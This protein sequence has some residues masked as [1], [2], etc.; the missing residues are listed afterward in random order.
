M[1]RAI[2]PP[3]C[4]AAALMSAGCAAESQLLRADPEFTAKSLRR[5]GIAVLGVV[6]V[7]EVTQ[8]RAP[9]IAA[10]ERVLRATR[11]DVPLVAAERV[12]AAVA[13]SAYRLFLLG[14]QMRGEP[15]SSWLALVAEATRGMAR[16]GLLARVESAPVRYGTRVVAS[17]VAGRQPESEVKVAGRDAHI[18]VQ[19]YDLTTRRVVFSGK[20]VGGSDAAP[21]L[22]P[23]P[24]DSADAYPPPLEPGAGP[25]TAGPAP[26]APGIPGPSDSPS[27]LGFPEA[28]P[29]ARAAEAAF[30]IFARSLPGGPPPP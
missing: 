27:A 21:I 18:A 7:E 20:Y 13:D 19:I 1:L 8:V 2:V 11:A 3:A 9:L 28:P 17:E 16:Y 5:G 15:D 26:G 14:Y 10:S 23:V 4:A 24:P 29:V 22:R 6:Q 12:Q 25:T 30:L